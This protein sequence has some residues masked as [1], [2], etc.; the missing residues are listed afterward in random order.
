MTQARSIL[1]NIFSLT[2]SEI[3]NKG[4]LFIS[5]AYLGRVLLPEGFN[6]IGFASAVIAYFAL[7]V[8]LGFG[9]VGTRE[10]A[11]DKEKATKYVDGI[12][13]IKLILSI[14][15]YL[16]LLIFTLLLDKPDEM[17]I[18]ILICGI[19]LFFHAIMLDWFWQGVEKMEVIAFRQIIT[20]LLNMV[21]FFIFIHSP[22]DAILAMI[23]LMASF[24]LNSAWMF[25]YYIRNFHNFKFN[26]DFILWKQ[27]IKP[28]MPL[29]IINVVISINSNF[30]IIALGLLSTDKEGGIFLAANK[31]FLLVTVAPIILQNSFYPA[32][33][34]ANIDEDRRKIIDKYALLL[35]L[36]G[37]FLT[38]LFFVFPDFFVGFTFGSHYRESSII[39]QT[40]VI[41]SLF[42]YITQASI[43]PLI[44]WKKETNV[45]YIF[46]II[47]S[48][49]VSM[50]LLL[51]PLYGAMGVSIAIIITEIVS[52]IIFEFYFRTIL[53]TRKILIFLKF[54]LYSAI[55]GSIGY[56]ILLLGVHP[57]LCIAISTAIWIGI[58]ALMKTITINELRGYLKR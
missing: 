37:T 22:S 9:A 38:T 41:A 36:S 30:A 44:A 43:N 28:S 57:A 50:N 19:N 31:I 29:L 27:L 12:L 56:L 45:M 40:M 25:L 6:K 23:I 10:V 51:A 8:N 14:F 13:T 18:I 17:K 46:M 2:V 58:N 4:L 49:N 20:C 21:G 5:T 26:F 11:I 35:F 24:A 34:R 32:F 55:S 15:A 16:L 48:V 7:I 42:V 52:A 1:K 53:K 47:G 54:M 39:L 33:S 3:A